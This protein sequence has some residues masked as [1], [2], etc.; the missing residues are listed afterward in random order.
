MEMK[1]TEYRT[2]I[3]FYCSSEDLDRSQKVFRNDGVR[4]KML[5]KFMDV[6]LTA[7]EKRGEGYIASLAYSEDDS[8]TVVR[9]MCEA[10]AN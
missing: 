4:G 9:R 1:N 2:K 5:N 7:A 6:L 10:G 3:C 8:I